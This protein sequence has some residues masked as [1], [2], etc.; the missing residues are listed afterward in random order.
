MTDKLRVA[1]RAVVERW[2]SPNWADLPHTAEYIHALREAL[3][4]PAELSDEDE[5]AAFEADSLRYEFDV[6]RWECAAPEPW[7]EYQ[8]LETGYRW[9][10]WLARANGIGAKP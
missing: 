7:S 3:T 4:E 8:S 5:R 9:S 6:T 10:G 1:A 2:D